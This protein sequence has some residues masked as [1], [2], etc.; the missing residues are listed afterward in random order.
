MNNIEKAILD[1][2]EQKYNKKFVGRIKVTKLGTGWAGYKVTLYHK[3]STYPLISLSAD[4][5]VEDFL[6][7]VEQELV[8]RQLIKVQWFTGIK[9][10]LCD[11]ERGT[12]QKNG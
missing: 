10:Y 3:N 9:N 1:I 2:I 5:E 7:F 8:S 6:K 11:E 12:C 4:L